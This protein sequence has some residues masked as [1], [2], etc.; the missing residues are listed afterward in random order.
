M[1][2]QALVSAIDMQPQFI[3]LEKGGFWSRQYEDW[4]Q[5]KVKVDPRQEDPKPSHQMHQPALQRPESN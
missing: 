4:K 2:T 5:P 3:Y 1:R